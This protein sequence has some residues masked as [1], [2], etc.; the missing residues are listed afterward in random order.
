MISSTLP[1]PLQNSLW[2]GALNA[3]DALRRSGVAMRR[4]ARQKLLALQPAS[5]LWCGDDGSG[6]VQASPRDPVPVVTVQVR[7]NDRVERGQVC[8]P[9]S[10]IGQPPAPQSPSEVGALTL[11]EEVRVGQHGERADPQ[12]RGRRADERQRVGA[13]RGR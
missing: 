12:D 3:G 7:E 10:G 4:L 5:R 6:P 11:A 2:A 13:D 8:D 1:L 9:D